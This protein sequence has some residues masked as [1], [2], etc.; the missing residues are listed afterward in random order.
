MYD[1]LIE[2]KPPMTYNDQAKAARRQEARD[3][4]ALRKAGYSDGYT[5][6]PGEGTVAPAAPAEEAQRF[7]VTRLP[8]GLEASRRAEKAAATRRRNRYAK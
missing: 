4:V 3:R 6:L 8:G 5:V 7:Q 1:T 2:I